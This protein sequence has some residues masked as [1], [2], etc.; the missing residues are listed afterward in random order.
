MD[1]TAIMR[2]LRDPET[3]DLLF[4][5]FPKKQTP[6]REGILQISDRAISYSDI[7]GF[8]DW[9]RVCSTGDNTKADVEGT[10]HPGALVDM[11]GYACWA[12]FDDYCEESGMPFRFDILK[13]MSDTADSETVGEQWD[14]YKAS[15]P[16]NEI[17]QRAC[18][19]EVWL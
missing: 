11:E 7:P 16:I 8:N 13:W 6:F 19:G 12:A 14:K 1:A 9:Q 4:P 10:Y 2:Q 5:D 15:M 3:G 17:I 18:T